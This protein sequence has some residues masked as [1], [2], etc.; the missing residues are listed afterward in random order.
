VVTDKVRRGVVVLQTGAW[1]D[2]ADPA[3]IGS[4]EKH[5]NP[6]V[7]TA[8]VEVARDTPDEPQVTVFDEPQI[9]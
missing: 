1:F 2:P 3:A 6:N 8:L 5:G 4:L 9:K 7:L